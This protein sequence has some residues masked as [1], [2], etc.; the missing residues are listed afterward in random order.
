MLA[1]IFLSCS[2]TNERHDEM[3]FLDQMILLFISRFIMYGFLVVLAIIATAAI[4]QL[5]GK[6]P[7]EAGYQVV[8]SWTTNPTITSRE[9]L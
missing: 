4:D 6:N 2:T 1:A 5:A 3:P 8:Q 9:A 7:L